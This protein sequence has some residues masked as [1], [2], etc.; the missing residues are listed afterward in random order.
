M[1]RP[2]IVLPISVPLARA[3]EVYGISRSSLYRLAA[4]GRIRLL[5]VGSTTLVDGLSMHELLASLPEA[6]I[7]NELLRNVSETKSTT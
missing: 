6:Q 7:R 3:P 5:K 4:A 1:T 2:T